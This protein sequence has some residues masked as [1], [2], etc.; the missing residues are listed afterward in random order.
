MHINYFNLVVNFCANELL[1]KQLKFTNKKKKKGSNGAWFGV[2]V[3]ANEYV[4]R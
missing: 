4:C 1:A 3:V 2:C